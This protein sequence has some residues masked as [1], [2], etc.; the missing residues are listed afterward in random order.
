MVKRRKDD[1]YTF[2]G[3]KSTKEEL[4]A[5][6]GGFGE[7]KTANI[8]ARN[9]II[10]LEK[11][12]ELRAILAKRLADENIY[13]VLEIHLQDREINSPH[14]QFIGIKAEEAE[15][16]IAET[17]VEMKYELSVENAI[18]RKD[19]IPFYEY[20]AHSKIESLSEKLEEQRQEQKFN[21]IKNENVSFKKQMEEERDKFYKILNEKIN[22]VK[23][24]IKQI[25]YPKINIKN[26]YDFYKKTTQELVDNVKERIN[27]LRKRR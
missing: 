20:E 24:T 9:I 16:I 2:T 22:N 4:L 26:N 5:L 6:L 23:K 25:S 13:G 14:I 8:W 1:A 3:A 15:I 19:Y 7:V 27:K 12:N 17:L 11:I 10:E 21:E 18:G